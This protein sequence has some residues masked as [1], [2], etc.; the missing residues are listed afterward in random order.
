MM[1]LKKMR[2]ESDYSD[3]I[4]DFN[5]SRNALNKSNELIAV[6]KKLN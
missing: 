4:I 2:H 1:E 6:I 5:K 3:A